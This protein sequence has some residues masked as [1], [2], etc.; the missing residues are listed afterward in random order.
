MKFQRDG[1][2]YRES[3]EKKTKKAALKILAEKLEEVQ[4]TARRED[5]LQRLLDHI[6]S[7]PNDKGEQDRARKECA[8]LLL[9]GVAAKL[10]I[11]EAW[12]AWLDSPRKRNPSPRT[13]Q[14]YEGQWRRFE[15]WIQ[16]H[17]GDVKHLH[18]VTVDIAE[19]YATNLWQDKVTPST[20]N[21]HIKCLR[22]TFRVL[23]NR[24]ALSQNPWDEIPT[25]ENEKESKRNLT[26][27]ELKLV[28]KK[29]EGDL[30]YWFAIGLYT[31]L[32]LGDVVTLKWSEVHLKEGII[33]RVPMKTRRKNKVVRFPIH[34]VLQVMLEELRENSKKKSDYLFPGAAA[35]YKRDHS[36]IV[37]KTQH[38]FKKECGI[39]TTEK[40]T[41]KH[42]S[43]PIVRVGFH[44]L[45]H[46]FVSLCAA[47]KVPEVA[48][49]EMVGHGSP[50]MTKLYSHAGD[51]QKAN[52][53]AAL[54][55]ISF[56]E[57]QT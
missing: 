16:K 54:P 51:E 22:A 9:N 23:K 24:A 7:L 43:R 37:K 48:I 27:K 10:A 52:A 31:G 32:R 20:F 49:M 4:G 55:S 46:S 40:A 33:E 47:N 45:R 38:F 17:H 21:A 2:L 30:R 57:E 42:R 53:I 6:E 44:S 26:P 29:A 56:K 35:L 12:Q 28:C 50:A 34:P 5:L 13:I 14:G 39:K 18:Q 36:A 15:K 3:T 25:M 1:K 11:A 19:E 41:G 8:S